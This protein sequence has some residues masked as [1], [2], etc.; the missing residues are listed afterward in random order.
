[1]LRCNKTAHLPSVPGPPTGTQLS[2]TFPTDALPDR[3]GSPF[4]TALLIST[5]GSHH[6]LEAFIQESKY[7]IH[8]GVFTDSQGSQR[9]PFLTQRDKQ[10]SLLR[11]R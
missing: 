6:Q 11:G 9:G 5:S 1:M 7:F 8:K 3:K 2:V 10:E 4:A